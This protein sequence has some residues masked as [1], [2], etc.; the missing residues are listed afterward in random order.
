M[1]AIQLET[2]AVSPMRKATP[3]VGDEVLQMLPKD[4]PLELATM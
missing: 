2:P 1:S 4:H 3:S